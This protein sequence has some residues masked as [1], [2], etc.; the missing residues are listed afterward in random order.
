MVSKADWK[1]V[2]KRNKARV[3]EA[4]VNQVAQGLIDPNAEVHSDPDGD[5]TDPHY[6]HNK[7]DRLA[8]EKYD[9][10]WKEKQ[11]A[12]AQAKEASK[13][14]PAQAKEASRSSTNP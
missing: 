2:V 11:K 10:E 1:A 5:P 4:Y 7:A 6:E 13:K 14:S 9:R 3:K 12:L 8:E